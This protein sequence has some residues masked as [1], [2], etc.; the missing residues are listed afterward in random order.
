MQGY[1]NRA[2]VTK[3]ELFYPVEGSLDGLKPALVQFLI[4]DASSNG[5]LTIFWLYAILDFV[6]HFSQQ[7]GETDEAVY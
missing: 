1:G 6:V 2:S 5:L 3:P 7:L 4:V